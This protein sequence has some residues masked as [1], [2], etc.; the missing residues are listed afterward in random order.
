MLRRVIS[1]KEMSM[2]YWKAIFI[3]VLLVIGSPAVAQQ[4]S[5]VSGTIKDDILELLAITNAEKMGNQMLEQ[6]FN[7]YEHMIPDVPVE[8]WEKARREMRS[9][10]MLELIIPIYAKHFSREDIR[11][12]I[13]FYKSPAGKKFIDKQ[14]TIMK[15]S[16]EIG[17]AWGH[18]VSKKI[19][20]EL[21]S[22]GYKVPNSL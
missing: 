15:E 16:M 7:A 13:T 22:K 1:A 10:D 21:K 11:G 4:D 2:R 8:V 12:L 20:A 5:L 9:G 18:E 19:E 3:I 6:I 14:E 17:M